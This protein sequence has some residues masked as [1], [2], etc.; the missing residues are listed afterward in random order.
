MNFWFF[1]EKKKKTREIN[2]YKN[3]IYI[4]TYKCVRVCVCM[5]PYKKAKPLAG[6][7]ATP[8]LLL[9]PR[10][11]LVPCLTRTARLA[12]HFRTRSLYSKKTPLRDSRISD[13]W[14]TARQH[15]RRILNKQGKTPDWFAF[16]FTWSRTEVGGGFLGL[17]LSPG[18]RGYK[19]GSFTGCETHFS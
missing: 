12:S 3:I 1:E 16:H 2:I 5:Y 4:H 7:N 11:C 10:P 8:S 14:E 13:T 17:P 9:L 19:A 15:R 6:G 18:S